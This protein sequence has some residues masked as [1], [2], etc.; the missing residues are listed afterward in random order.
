MNFKKKLLFT[1][2]VTAVFYLLCSIW[3]GW[4]TDPDH[5]FSVPLG[6]HST[7]SGFRVQQLYNPVH[8]VALLSWHS[9]DTIGLETIVSD[10]S[11]RTRHVGDAR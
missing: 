1:I 10:F 9:Q 4:G 5:V 11:G 6:T 8:K 7:L 3:A 2:A